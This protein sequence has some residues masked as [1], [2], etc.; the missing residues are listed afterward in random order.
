MFFNYDAPDHVL[1]LN[2][3]TSGCIGGCTNCSADL[4][5]FGTCTSSEYYSTA[6]GTC[7]TGV[8]NPCANG[9][10]TCTTY[11]QG[12]CTDCEAPLIKSNCNGANCECLCPN[13][14]EF[15]SS[16]SCVACS[17]PNCSVCLSATECLTCSDEHYWNPSTRTCTAPDPLIPYCKT[18][19][20]PNRCTECK[21][22]KYKF[23]HGQAL[24]CFTTC[25]TGYSENGGTMTC[26]LAGG[27]E[28]LH[29]KYDGKITNNPVSIEG[30]A[31]KA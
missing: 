15:Y 7:E 22:G 11:D 12:G 5:C 21:S 10:S 2:N 18:Y 28:V 6:T 4:I 19:S 9:C 1:K 16:G 24:M 27:T 20:S 29:Y 3:V 31:I 13:G 17:L 25:P 14:N 23:K 8:C 30:R 26:D